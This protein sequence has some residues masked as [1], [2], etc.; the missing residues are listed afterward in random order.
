MTLFCA[1]PEAF[2]GLRPNVEV[3]ALPS[4]FEP[5]GSEPDGSVD[6]ATPDV[7]HC[8]PVGWPGIR[9]ATARLA[10]W[11]DSADPAVFISDVSAE[12]ALFARI[13]SVPHIMVRQHGTRNDP[14]HMAAYD[15]AIGLLAPFDA[16]LAQPDWPKRHLEQT[17]FAGGLG[18][19]A[20]MPTRQKARNRLGIVADNKLA[21]VVTSGDPS[22]LS[23]AAIAVGART[24]P[25]M[26][27]VTLGN[28]ARDWHATEPTNLTHEGWVDNA[29]DWIA[30]AD[31]V[32]SST[33]NTTCHQVLA[34]G[35][36]WLTIP[37]WRYFDEQVEKAKALARANAATVRDHAPSSAQAWRDAIRE[38]LETHERARA[39]ALYT[40]DAAVKAAHWLETRIAAFWG[41]RADHRVP[42]TSGELS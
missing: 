24:F 18:V 20:D 19:R 38:T 1:Q 3:I 9:A 27:W 10:Q 25:A 16:A 11:F 8:A 6:I 7:L 33:G 17:F 12:L 21:V 23:Q 39:K 4:L 15:A 36:P 42:A 26:Q 5:M 29:E 32:I 30:A 2:V 13:C 28:I 31:V 14:G 41:D 35:V 40:P 22:G 37:E 34:A